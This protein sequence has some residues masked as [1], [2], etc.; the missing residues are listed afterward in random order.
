MA[1]AALLILVL[2]T[3]IR[4][5]PHAMIKT[6]RKS[7]RTFVIFQGR[8]SRAKISLGLAISTKTTSMAW[9]PLAKTRDSRAAAM[10]GSTARGT[11]TVAMKIGRASCRAS[12][13]VTGGAA[14]CNIAGG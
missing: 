1:M 3:I 2:M 11:A 13:E 8:T 14:G 4:K 10:T 12:V 6:L 7:S 9:M 5:E